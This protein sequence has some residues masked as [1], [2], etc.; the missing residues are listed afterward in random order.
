[1][2]VGPTFLLLGNFLFSAKSSVECH[3]LLPQWMRKE[4][5]AFLSKPAHQARLFGFA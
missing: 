1:M 3:F 2:I 4:N 5:G